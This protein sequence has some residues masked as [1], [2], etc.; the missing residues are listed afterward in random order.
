MKLIVV[1]CKNRGIGFQNSLPWILKSDLKRFQHLT[2][3]N[4][5]NAI[6]MG[7]N[8]W[9]SLPDKY[10]PLPKRTNIVLS[11]QYFPSSQ[12]F[13]SL[14]DAKLFCDEKK[15]DDIWIIGGEKLYNYALDKQYI[16][17]IYTTEINKNYVCDAFFPPIPTDFIH[18]ST[19]SNLK[20]NDMTFKFETFSKK[21][22]ITFAR[23]T[24]I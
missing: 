19:H 23:N 1:F 6:I 2:M 10:K 14:E 7:R 17:D 3:G 20:E 4:G 5:N 18:T 24:D 15:F 12:V 22:F 13:S 16:T 9:D 8:T 11:S 21:K